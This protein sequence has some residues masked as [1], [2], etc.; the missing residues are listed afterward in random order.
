MAR[1]PAPPFDE[2]EGGV[3]ANA[4][5]QTDWIDVRNYGNFQLTLA[6]Q[7]L[8]GSTQASVTNDWIVEQS[9]DGTDNG[10]DPAGNIAGTFV[11]TVDGTTKPHVQVKTFAPGGDVTK[12]ASWIRIK[13]TLAGTANNIKKTIQLKSLSFKS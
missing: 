12:W 9:F 3:T 4:T 5:G 11:Q 7:E 8:T 13:W 1:S 6:V 10:K 2:I